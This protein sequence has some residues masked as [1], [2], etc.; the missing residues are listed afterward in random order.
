MV[1]LLL[2]LLLLLHMT[3]EKLKTHTYN[4]TYTCSAFYIRNLMLPAYQI[5]LKLSAPYE[6]FSRPGLKH[7]DGISS[8]SASGMKNI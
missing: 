7:D 1:L 6:G 2:L 4:Y 3:Y 5:L 8:L